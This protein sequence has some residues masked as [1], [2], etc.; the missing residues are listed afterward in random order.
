MLLV[1]RSF[2]ALGMFAGRRAAQSLVAVSLAARIACRC[3]RCQ[4]Q[5]V[6]LRIERTKGSRVI[7]LTVSAVCVGSGDARQSYCVFI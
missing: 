4:Q 2:W 5:Q 3:M 6:L 7:A 1:K